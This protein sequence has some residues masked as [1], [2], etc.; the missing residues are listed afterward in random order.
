MQKI[1]PEDAILIPDQ[2][3]CVFKGEIY[4]VYQWPQTMFDGSSA[5]FEMLKRADT[6]VSICL[7]GDK[8]IVLDD[9]QPHTG[10]RKSFPSGRV[11]DSD[12]SLQAAAEREVLEETGYR[13]K[14]WRLVR[15]EQPHLKIEWFVYLFLAW[16]PDGEKQP[17]EPDRGEKITLH[18]LSFSELK[19][20]VLANKGLL[21][22]SL[23]LIEDI[24]KSDELLSLPEFKGIVADR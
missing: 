16:E 15:V 4:D 7:V 11:E 17:P 12:D 23:S 20:L 19:E 8:V 1:L 24:N 6:V 5:T 18:E 21:G 9:E 10:S 2:A 13:F 22:E 14:N 3:Q